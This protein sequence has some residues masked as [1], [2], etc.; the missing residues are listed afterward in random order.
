M[1]QNEAQL[2]YSNTWNGMVLGWRLNSLVTKSDLVHWGGVFELW[3]VESNWVFP[4]KCPAAQ[5]GEELT[6][7][8]SSAPWMHKSR[9]CTWS[10]EGKLTV[11]NQ[12]DKVIPVHRL[13][14]YWAVILYQCTRIYTGPLAVW[15]RVL[16]VS[17]L[18]R[19]LLHM[20]W[21]FR[22]VGTSQIQNVC[23][24]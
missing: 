12:S 7:L 24:Y 23:P 22:T 5:A 1:M 14:E 6:P 20:V 19:L 9:L 8:D 17:T 10:F 15:H 21:I 13:D 4:T 16:C 11:D 18:N 3:G 2:F